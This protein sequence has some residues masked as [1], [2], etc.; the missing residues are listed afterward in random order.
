MRCSL[1]AGPTRLHGNSWYTARRGEEGFSLIEV[2]VV[3][4]IIALL[5][6]IALPSFLHQQ[7]KGQDAEAKTVRASSSATSRPASSRRTSYTP[8]T[9][10]A[11][12]STVMNFPY[13]N[14]AGEAEIVGAGDDSFT[15]IAHSRSGADFRIVKTGG[16]HPERTCSPRDGGCQ[17]RRHL[18]APLAPQ[19]GSAARL[20]AG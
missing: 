6:A 20:S 14:Q 17:R 19:N 10:P 3:V 16:Q 12:L 7:K 4:L 2:L 1:V 5:A 8:V 18:V 15:V 11:E 9:R 13:G